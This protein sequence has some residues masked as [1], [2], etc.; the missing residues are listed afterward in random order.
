MPKVLLI[1]TGG[2]LGALARYFLGGLVHRLSSSLFPLGT[3]AVNALGCFL[4][5][6]VMTLVLERGAI[7]PSGRLFV[8]IGFLGSF[9]TFSTFGYET[10]ELLSDGEW[11]LAFSNIA[12][13]LILGIGA[14]LA[15]RFLVRLFT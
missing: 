2:F 5:G 3:L 4:I 15:G 12:A 7:G 8:A 13:Q 14:V 1:G 9:T 11:T 6:I 10:V